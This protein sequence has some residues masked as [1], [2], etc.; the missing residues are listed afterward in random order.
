M[1]ASVNRVR[2]G[3]DNGLS[4]GRRQAIILANAD[5][6]FNEILFE[7]KVF[8][9]K[10]MRMNTS[11]AKWRPFCS[12]GDELIDEDL[13]LHRYTISIKQ[14]GMP[15]TVSQPYSDGFSYKWQQSHKRL[16]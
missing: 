6:S 11:P 1:Y 5:I 14:W 8:S 3:S 10:K 7:I 9:F 15:Y 16:E 2:I 4:P 13:V 12:G